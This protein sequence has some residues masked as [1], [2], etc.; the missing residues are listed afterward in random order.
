[1]SSFSARVAM[2]CEN[3]SDIAVCARNNLRPVSWLSSFH[4][5]FIFWC[6]VEIVHKKIKKK[7]VRVIDSEVSL[8]NQRREKPTV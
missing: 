8:T 6:I 3:N 1:M 7:S 2:L 5:I 4:D